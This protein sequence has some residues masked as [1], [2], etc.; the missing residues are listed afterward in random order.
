MQEKALMNAKNLL[1]PVAVASLLHGCAY[2][3]EE[4]VAFITKT[5]IGLDVDGTPPEVSFAYNRVE[6]Y[7]GPRYENGAVPPVASALSTDGSILNRGIKQFY[8]TGDAARLVADRAATPSESTK[9]LQ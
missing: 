6:G 2:K 5:S 9:E 3:P 8:A 1:L 7:L 4:N